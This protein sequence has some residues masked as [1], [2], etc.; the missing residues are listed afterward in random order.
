MVFVPDDEIVKFVKEI[1]AHIPQVFFYCTFYIT[2]VLVIILNL[3]LIQDTGLANC[4]NSIFKAGKADG[5]QFRNMDQTGFMSMSCR[6]NVVL[7]TADMYRGETYRLVAFFHLL[8]LRLGVLFFCYDVICRYWGFAQKI[9]RLAQE[10]KLSEE[11]N[12]LLSVL[13]TKTLPFLSRFHGQ[14]HAWFCQVMFSFK[15]I[16]L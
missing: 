15:N 1:N 13:V 6:H 11:L 7:A 8:A 14:A 9:A 4:G 12:N 10:K 5:S 2:R 16:G 3:L